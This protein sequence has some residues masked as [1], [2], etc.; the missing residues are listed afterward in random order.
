MN[1][2]NQICMPFLS[3]EVES[4]TFPE[5]MGAWNS[6]YWHEGEIRTVDGRTLVVQT[7]LKDG[8][9]VIARVNGEDF[10]IKHTLS[11][12]WI[13][14]GNTVAEV[15]SAVAIGQAPAIFKHHEEL[16]AKQKREADKVQKRE[17]KKILREAAKQIQKDSEAA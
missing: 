1:N 9:A 3:P 4:H 6:L 16:H 13:F 10:E 5:Y 8:D 14:R 2:A 7:K 15:I 12:L 11:P 17:V